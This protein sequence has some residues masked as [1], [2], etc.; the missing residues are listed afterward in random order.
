MKKVR[1]AIGVCSLHFIK[2]KK[3]FAKPKNHYI[4][5]VEHNKL[6]ACLVKADANLR[7]VG[8]SL[9]CQDSGLLFR[10]LS[11]CGY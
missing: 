4:T 9:K 2:V 3:K 6:S 5:T 8:C 11:T 1:L 7:L 10:S